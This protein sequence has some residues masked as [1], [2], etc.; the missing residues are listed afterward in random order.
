MKSDLEVDAGAVRDSAFALAGSGARVAAGAAQAPPAVLIPR[1][2]TSDTASALTTAAQAWLTTIASDVTA[3]G[4]DL[5]AT[6]GDYEAADD[7]S[8]NRLRAVR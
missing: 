8:A 6:A 3:A 4:R 5:T 1:W 7:R 2:A